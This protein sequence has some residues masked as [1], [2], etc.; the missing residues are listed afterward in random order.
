MDNE[1]SLGKR[2]RSRCSSFAA[3]KRTSRG[4]GGPASGLARAV[5]VGMGKRPGLIPGG[6]L[7]EA[8]SLLPYV[9][10]E[11]LR[12]ESV[13]R[14]GRTSRNCA[15]GR[16]EVEGVRPSRSI[17]RVGV[18]RTSPHEQVSR[19]ATLVARRDR[20]EY[21]REAPILG[22]FSNPS[23]LDMDLPRILLQVGVDDKIP[24]SLL[25]RPIDLRRPNVFLPRSVVN[26]LAV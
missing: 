8:C 19:R 21:Y 4:G 9:S 10:L 22:V 17:R 14:V 16:R 24:S 18:P 25:S 23:K 20:D 12:R 13:A 15:S 7:S 26:I 3:G 2:P 6:R 1:D 11:E 5:K